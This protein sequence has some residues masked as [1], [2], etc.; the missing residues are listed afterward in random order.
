V[1]VS[2]AQFDEVLSKLKTCDKLALDTETTG[3]RPY[4]GDRLFSIILASSPDTAWYFNFQPYPGLDP[5]AILLPSHLDRLKTELLEASITR[6]WFIHNAKFDLAVLHAEGIELLGM[7]HCTKALGLVEYNEHQSYGLDASLERI[8]LKKD[9]RVE[10]FI[11]ENKL[12]EKRQGANQQY[13]HKFYNRVPYDIIVPYGLD[14]AKGCFA[15]GVHQELTIGAVA[16]ATPPTLPNLRAVLQNEK[17]LT[18]TVFRM[19]ALGVKIDRPYCLR[20]ARFEADRAEKAVASFKRETG[21]DFKVSPKLLAEVFGDQR[22]LWDFTDKGNPSFTSDVLR[23]FKSPTAQ[24]VLEYRDAKSKQDFYQGFLYHADRDDL[25]HPNYNQDGAGHGRFSSSNPN[26]QNLTAEEGQDLEQEFVVRRAVIPRPG[27]VF[28]MPDYDQMEYR[29]MFDVACSLL[30]YE[31]D[32]VKEIKNGKDPHQATADVVTGMGTPLTRSRAKNGNFAYL[33]GSGI[34][35][36]AATIGSTESEAREL[37]RLMAAA[38]PEVANYIAAIT[39]TAERRRFIFNWLGRRCYFPDARFAYRA[40]N[41]HIAGGCADVVKVVM[42]RLD[43]YFLQLKS[44]MVMTVHDELPI[45]CHE[46]ELAT[47]P[48]QVKDIMESVY[49]SKYL[50][51]TAGMEYSTKSLAD[52]IKGFPV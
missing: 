41:Y 36:L 47:V 20:A 9:D 19:E 11:T 23:R 21:R 10:R 42:N 18:R 17:R 6:T 5:E 26:F 45:E 30:G 28:L 38:T 3:L 31:S 29:M 4:H 13:T 44:R 32:V 15:L 1:I 12:T 25:I 49:P 52:K 48:R 37:K 39:G 40:P 43:D 50:P 2:R 51:L 27:F 34:A 46:S 22:D 24:A 14:D 35:T 8:G 33:Y 16:D 7:V